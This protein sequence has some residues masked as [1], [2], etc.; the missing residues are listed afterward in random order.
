MAHSSLRAHRKL[1]RL[2]RELKV[3]LPLAVGLL[4][5]LWWSAYESKGVGSDGVLHG[6][7]VRDIASASNWV[8]EAGTFAEGLC[9]A[10]FLEQDDSATFSIHDYS[11]WVP[12]YVKK[13]WK[14]ASDRTTAD[15]IRLPNATQPNQTKPKS[16]KSTSSPPAARKM[17]A[18]S[19]LFDTGSKKPKTPR[20]RN[21]TWDACQAIQW[22]KGVP[23]R[24][25]ARCGRLCVDFEQLGADPDDIGPAFKRM[26]DTPGWPKAGRT[27]ES[28]AK[29]WEQFRKDSP[30]GGDSGTPRSAVEKRRADQA[31]RE[32][33]EPTGIIPILGATNLED[34]PDPASQ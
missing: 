14:R 23:P 5:F 25:E 19:C 20:P 8:G 29:H 18:E 32:F 26:C 24:Q 21:P 12:D 7:T 15:N 34:R 31:A 2:C 16:K 28:L 33:P 9:I 27:L 1:N 30:I 6:W 22:P 4:E 17:R 13:R 10:G 3:S 11:D